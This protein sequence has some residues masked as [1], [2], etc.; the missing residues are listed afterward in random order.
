MTSSFKNTIDQRISLKVSGTIIYVF[1]VLF[2]DDILLTFDAFDLVSET[3]HMLSHHFDT[4][5]LREASYV[6]DIHILHDRTKC[7]LSLSQKATLIKF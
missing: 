5:D 2:I 4:K 7:I 6:L 1:L 3:K